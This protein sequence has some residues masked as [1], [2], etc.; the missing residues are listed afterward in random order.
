MLSC[1]PDFLMQSNDVYALYDH[2]YQ[3]QLDDRDNID[4]N[5][6]RLMIE[7]HNG[8]FL[9]SCVDFLFFWAAYKFGGTSWEKNK[10]RK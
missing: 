2:E 10:Q 3:E 1:S 5:F 9:R 6:F 8:K 4:F 7:E